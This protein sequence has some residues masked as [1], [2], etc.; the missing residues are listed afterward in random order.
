ML[1]VRR[2]YS[3]SLRDVRSPNEGVVG[4]EGDIALE[5][6]QRSRERN[7]KR[8]GVEANPELPSL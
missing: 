6:I 2:T 5:N 3:E 8:E 1:T 7:A 4:E